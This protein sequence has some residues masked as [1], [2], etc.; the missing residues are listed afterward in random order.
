MKNKGKLGQE[1][2]WASSL[3]AHLI[4]PSLGLLGRN[5]FPASAQPARLACPS[6][7]HARETTVGWHAGPMCQTLFSIFPAGTP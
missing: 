1:L 4:L 6:L 3:Q 5:T 7:V 2:L